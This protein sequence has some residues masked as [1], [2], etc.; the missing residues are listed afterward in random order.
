MKTEE[1]VKKKRAEIAEDCVLNSL[2]KALIENARA[3]RAVKV[4]KKA[5]QS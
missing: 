2:A 1:E 5:A 3:N 4:Q